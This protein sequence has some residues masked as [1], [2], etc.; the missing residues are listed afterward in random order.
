MTLFGEQEFHQEDPFNFLDTQEPGGRSDDDLRLLLMQPEVLPCDF[1]KT[2]EAWLYR[3]GIWGKI[4]FIYRDNFKKRRLTEKEFLT[5]MA[6]NSELDESDPWDVIKK[7]YK[8]VL[9]R[10]S[11]RDQK[12][13]RHKESIL[14][15]IDLKPSIKKSMKM[16]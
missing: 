1:D 13:K 9:F 3:I 14:V 16:F 2:F 15:D 12:G 4:N 7:G 6:D 8:T 10:R 5:M 11:Y